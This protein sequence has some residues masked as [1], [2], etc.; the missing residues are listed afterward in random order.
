MRIATA[1]VGLV[2][3]ATAAH[4][5]NVLRACM[6]QAAYKLHFSGVGYVSRG[7][8]IT[9][10]AFGASDQNGKLPVQLSTRFNIG[11]AGKMFTSVAIGQLV[12]R[13]AIRLDAPIATY[14]KALPPALAGITIRQLLAHTSGLGDYLKP[15]NR[16]LIDK[17]RTA[18]ALLPLAIANSPAF[19]PG[20]RFL[21]SNSGYVVLGAVI[22]EV[23]KLSYG[24]Y[25][26]Q[27]IFAPAG[28][29]DTNLE[30]A[31]SAD[32]MTRMSPA[33]LAFASPAGGEVSTAADM[34][35]FLDALNN[36]RLV[37]AAAR[38]ELFAPQNAPGGNT[39]YGL[40][41]AVTAGPP[42]KVGHGGGAPGINAEIALFPAS[43]SKVV[44]LSNYDPPTASRLALVLEHALFADDEAAAC[45][46][47]LNDPAFNSRVPAHAPP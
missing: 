7:S 47:A 34:A 25:L 23:S 11:S 20:S 38:S 6:R 45:S 13:G 41:F 22:E 10:E 27:Q 32:P 15:Q 2:L 40:G 42:V 9:A 4:A 5:D 43:G 1:L 30:T 31:G 36:G 44:T 14:L 28:M 21:Y 37:T 35:R 19:V 18:T 46:S 24:D 17:A 3:S 8:D 39:Q 26:R 12:D 33:G 29:K 16:E